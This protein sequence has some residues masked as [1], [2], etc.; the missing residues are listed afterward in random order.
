MNYLAK[1][2]ACPAFSSFPFQA[3][4]AEAWRALPKLKLRFHG[5]GMSWI[6]L[7]ALKLTEASSSDWPPDR[8]TMPG[9][10]A[11]TVLLKAVTVARATCSGDAFLAHFCPG[12]TIL[13]LRSVPSKYTWW[14]LRALYVAAN[15]VSVTFWH[16]SMSWSPS[17]STSGSTIG[18]RRLA[19]QMEAY[20]AK[21]FAFS[22]M[23]W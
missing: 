9:T 18:T 12:V 7:M 17:Q 3:F 8:N 13:G 10:A 19:W 11:G 16:L 2:A 4:N 23:A 14:S 1:Y 6:W 21:T 22:N 20:L 15:T 5:L